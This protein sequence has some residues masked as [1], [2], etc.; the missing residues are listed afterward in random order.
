MSTATTAG[1]ATAYT[2]DS[3]HSSVGFKIRHFMIAYVRGAFSGV[4]G[5]VIFDPANPANTKINASIDI[6][7]LHTLDEKRDAH[8]KGADF[9]DAANNPKMTFVS[10]KVV[11]DGKN[12]WK[13]TGD[14]TMRGV[15][16]EV[17]LDVE[18]AGVEAKDPWGNLRTGASAEGVIKRADYGLTFNAPLETGGFMLGDDVH[19]HMDIEMVRKA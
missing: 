17:T 10:K 9:L 3:A 13:V 6:N 16:K 19:I 12:H 7:T 4:T 2:I 14:F 11:A 18:S 15:T 8:V 5:D 1:T